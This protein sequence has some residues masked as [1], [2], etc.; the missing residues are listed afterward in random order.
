[1]REGRKR[2]R[3]AVGADETST[4]VVV[5]RA[6]QP[7]SPSRSRLG[8]HIVQKLAKLSSSAHV[9]GLKRTDGSPT[10]R[11]VHSRAKSTH[12]APA[13]AHGTEKGTSCLK[14]RF[15]S[16]LHQKGS[17][18]A[19]SCAV[20]GDGLPELQ[21]AGTACNS[22]ADNPPAATQQDAEAPGDAQVAVREFSNRSVVVSGA[23]VAGIVGITRAVHNQAATAPETSPE[24]PCAEHGSQPDPAGRSLE[25]PGPSS[26]VVQAAGLAEPVGV[27]REP[28]TVA[29]A[30]EARANV[31][32]TEP[33]SGGNVNDSAGRTDG[34]TGT[35]RRGPER[36]GNRGGRGRGSARPQRQAAGAGR[37]QAA[38]PPAAAAPQPRADPPAARRRGRIPQGVPASV[39]SDWAVAVT[40]CLE[41]V[42]DAATHRQGQGATARLQ[43][44]L[45]ALAALPERVLADNKAG[46]SRDRRIMARLRRIAEGQRVDGDEERDELGQPPTGPRRRRVSEQALLAARI[47]RYV[48]AGSIK[49]GAA[50]LNAEPLAD[51]SDPAVLEKLR[52]L[53][54]EA[55][56]PAALAIDEPALEVSAET[57]QAVCKRVSAHNRGTAGG[58]TGWTYE[59]ICACVQASEDGLR[60]TL[61]F[62]NLILSGTLPRSGFVLDSVMVGLMKL[63]DGVPNGGV[64]PIAIGEAWYRLA[65][66]CALTS[67]GAAVGADLAPLQVGVGTRGG[68]DAVAHAVATALEADPLNV[69]CALDCENAFN[70]VSRDAVFAAVRN[71]V[72]SLLPV[73]Q[74]AYGAAT[75][76]HV[77]G[78]RPGTEPIMSQCGVRQGDP[79]GPLL[80]ALALQGPLERAAQAVPEAPEVAYLDD[81]TIVGRPPAVRRAV[82]Q[83]CGIGPDSLHKI[84]L[85]V[86]KDKS[87]L[88]GGNDEQCS[89]LSAELGV[90]HRRDGVTIVGVPFGT[91]AY[92]ARVLGQR[93]QKVVALIDKCRSL[94]LSAQTKFLLLR[95][96]LAVRMVH[97][98]R[99]V[100]WCHLEPSTRGVETAVLS[101]AAELFRLAGGDGPG[102]F[103]PDPSRELDQMQLPFA[104]GGFGLRTTSELDAHAAFLSG[105]ASAQLVMAEAKRQFRP[106]DNAGVARLRQLWQRVFDDCSGDCG[107][108]AERRALSDSTIRQVLPVVQRDVARC[109]SARKAQA[110]LASC[111]LGQASG[112]REAARLRS[113]ANGP[114]SAW[115]LA[116]PGPTTKLGDSTFIACGRH[117]LGLGAP[118]TVQPRPCLCGAG[119]AATPDHAMVCKS[120]AKQTQMRHDIVA[121]AVRRVVCRAGC[122]SSLEPS[123]R[124]LRNR[125]VA[126][127]RRG[128]IMVVLPSGKISI[129][130]VV[131]THPSQ[132]AHV[133]QAS[134]RSGHAA[135]HAERSKVSE[136]RRIGEDA[137]Q[138]DFV[139]FAVESYGRLGA[140]AQSFLKQLGAVAAADGKISQAAFVRSAYRE[141]SC[142]LQRGLGQMYGRSLFN[143]A[144]ASGRQFMPGLDVPVQEEGLV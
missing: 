83:L 84:G 22:D 132:Q 35:A 92:K 19:R 59:M 78:A 74:W 89:Q 79:L 60:A 68:V 116:T 27:E 115:L 136:F 30:G 1:M 57:L 48:S 13:A 77:A 7:R 21:V 40:R 64:R 33:A 75:P 127:Q 105:A 106:F 46:R 97:L 125:G 2:E 24:S 93:A 95:S 100:E 124:H 15:Q 6:L 63:T 123:Y 38:P 119:N 9:Y 104:H 11:K 29:R 112:K 52:A 65:M 126:G 121:Y 120:V 4:Q 131:V 39:H 137:G 28:R 117:R 129:V 17:V 66:L 133:N 110:L 61:R 96:S 113:A 111:D 54:P 25:R 32:V 88:F 53:H 5:S 56:P 69:V 73:V 45:E 91:D 134:T 85:K 70:T 102:G 8:S 16:L 130:D 31:P 98:Q 139:P 10:V 122:A 80:F 99:S 141:V 109:T 143:I 101:A 20:Q 90:P 128:D 47:E 49:R 87:N 44:A 142:A 94:P 72:P 51:A 14:A 135:A 82:Q 67:V 58:L 43:S 71:R 23:P 55:E 12:R 144:R 3:E 118:T 114:A 108:P 81:M 138:Y 26:R 140:S 36:P 107:W 18:E 86:R 50:A 103:S 34:G 42:I 41:D 37:Q 62:I 76:L